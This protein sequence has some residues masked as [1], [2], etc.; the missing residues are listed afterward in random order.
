M[1][2]HAYIMMINAAHC[3]ITETVVRGALSADVERL[4]AFA[5]VQEQSSIQ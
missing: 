4:L 3:V 5:P 2:R 1:L